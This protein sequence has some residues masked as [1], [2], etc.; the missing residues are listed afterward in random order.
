MKSRPVAER[1]TRVKKNP[2]PDHCHAC[3]ETFAIRRCRNCGDAICAAHR[4]STGDP[5]DG[6]YCVDSL[7]VP[8][9]NLEVILAPPW[10]P[11][12]DPT[13]RPP[14]KPQRPW[15]PVLAFVAVAVFTVLAYWAKG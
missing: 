1:T 12:N 14:P 11:T 5:K 6:Y 3:V 10:D 2:V 8:V 7:C 4:W 9:D 15:A 13:L